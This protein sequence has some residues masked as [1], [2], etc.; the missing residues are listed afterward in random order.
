LAKG[1][2]PGLHA[3]EVGDEITVRIVT[4]DLRLRGILLAHHHAS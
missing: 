4:V 2:G 3:A 1:P